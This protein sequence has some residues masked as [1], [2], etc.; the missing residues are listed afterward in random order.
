MAAYGIVVKVDMLPLNIGMGLCQGMMPLVA[1]NYAAK[2]YPRMKAFTKAAQLSGMAVACIFIA[3]SQVFASQIVWLF[4]KDA[5]TIRFGTN[6]L[7]IACLATPFMISNFQKIYCLQAMGKGKESLLLGI[8]R[9]GL[10]AIPT[11]L[12]MNHFVG[13]Y[14]VVAAQL[15]SD[16]MTFIIST[17]LFRKV[18]NSLRMET[19]ALE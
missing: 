3:F 2:N 17:L 1:Y 15:I 19:G 14:G 7:R 11:L 13:L 8:C 4:I 9:Q 6:F 12:I 18:Y 16:G 5:E 10:F